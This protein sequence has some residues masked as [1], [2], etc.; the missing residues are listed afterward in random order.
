MALEPITAGDE[1]L[2]WVA[3]VELNGDTAVAFQTGYTF[4]VTCVT[5]G[6]TTPLLFTKT[7][8]ITGSAGTVTVA[9]TSTDLGALAA[10]TYSLKL[11]IRSSG[12]KD[13]TVDEDI[14]VKPVFA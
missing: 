9:W 12:T 1:L 11:R 14:L 10:G 5:K 7:T 3:S 6:T 13:L 8:G 4:Q 2:D